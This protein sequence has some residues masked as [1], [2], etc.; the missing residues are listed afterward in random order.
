M[1]HLNGGIP[2]PLERDE[3][4]RII[5]P[6]SGPVLP[7]HNVRMVPAV[8]IHG[9]KAGLVA[10]VRRPALLALLAEDGTVL[11]QQPVRIPPGSIVA[12][13]LPETAAILR[14]NLPGAVPVI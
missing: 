11:D 6:G 2:V 3:R 9:F 14:L 5:T 10:D 7:L 13:V 12:I 8:E 4:P 1:E